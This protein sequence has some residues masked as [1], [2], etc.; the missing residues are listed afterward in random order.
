[1]A[2]GRGTQLTKQIGEHLVAAELGRRGYIA[3]PFSGHVPLF[4]LLIADEFGRSVPIQVKAING[5]I[6]RATWQF[7]LDNFLKIDIVRGTQHVRGRVP[8][9][10]PKLLCIF[11]LLA[12]SGK[13]RFFIFPVCE[14][15]RHFAKCFGK[16]F[17]RPKNPESK[18]CAISPADLEKYEDNWK[19]IYESLRARN[20][21]INS[22]RIAVGTRV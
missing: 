22:R 19:I 15:Q 10:N 2:T 5:L 18:H 9:A 14:L 17:K 8:L 16:S 4:D 7:N 13:D 6:P 21:R 3:T 20:T 12:E 1:M 11:V